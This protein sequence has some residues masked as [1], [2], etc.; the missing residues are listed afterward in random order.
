[1]S[2]EIKTKPTQHSVKELRTI[3]IQPDILACRSVQPLPDAHREKIALFTNVAVDDVISLV[4][5]ESIYEI[6]I[7]VQKEGLG[8]RV[9]SKLQLNSQ[10]ADLSS[11]ERVV[12][13][14][15]NPKHDVHIAMVGK[16]VE[17]ADSYKSLNEALIHAGIQTESR[18]HIHYIDSEELER[19]GV[20]LLKG[21]DA[22]LVPGGFGLR[23]IEGK[24][25]AAQYAREQQIPYLGI[26]LGLQIAI[27][28]F[29]RHC[30]KIPGANSTELILKRLIQLLHWSVNGWIKRAQLSSVMRLK[31]WG[32]PCDWVVIVSVNRRIVGA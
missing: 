26:C 5:V 20:V 22:I 28:E 15:K 23:G 32:A 1:M 30:A 2:G 4:D 27:I 10:Q 29:A 25:Q 9:S 3:G 14:H 7:L 8:E 11:W 13:R 21:I 6:P 17:L 24:I 19:Q 18:V 12:S 31:I 16:Y